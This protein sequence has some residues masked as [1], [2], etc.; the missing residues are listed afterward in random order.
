MDYVAGMGQVSVG[1]ELNCGGQK[2]MAELDMTIEQLLK[3]IEINRQL[4]DSLENQLV[5]KSKPMEEG[6][7]KNPEV[8]SSQTLIYVLS[9]AI[10]RIEKSNSKLD[11]MLGRCKQVVGKAKL[12]EY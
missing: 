7:A 3:T 1:P 10:N 6:E 4:V 11:K 12:Y 5:D 2:Q 8:S 9:G